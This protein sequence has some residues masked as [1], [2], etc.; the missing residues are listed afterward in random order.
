MG[1]DELR[2]SECTKATNLCWPSVGR[3]GGEAPP[4]APTRE[5]WGLG[6]GCGPG[7]GRHHWEEGRRG[8]GKREI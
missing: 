2:G 5:G 8:T 7:Q 1:S 6:D 4:S 3:G